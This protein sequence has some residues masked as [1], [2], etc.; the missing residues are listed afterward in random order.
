MVDDGADPQNADGLRFGA[1]WR[2]LLRPEEPGP[3]PDIVVDVIRPNDLV[4]LSVA[5]YDVELDTE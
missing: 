2:H 4:S 1:G 5:G 3:A